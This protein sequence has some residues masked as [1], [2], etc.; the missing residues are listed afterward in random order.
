MAVLIRLRY[1]YAG[2]EYLLEKNNHTEYRE[3]AGRKRPFNIILGKKILALR[4]LQGLNQLDL[5]FKLGYE[6]TG[7]ISLIE[8]GQ[9]G[10]KREK[11]YEA[12]R[13]F[14]VPPWV[15][16][17]DREYT[18][19]ELEL[20]SNF[21]RLMDSKDPEFYGAIKALLKQAAQK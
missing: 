17:D 1:D 21:H 5:A 15:L 18:K 19:E 7:T 3:M 10:M 2:F 11:V 16:F 8:T 6:S 12:A 14:N 20:Y 4:E 9:A 13:L